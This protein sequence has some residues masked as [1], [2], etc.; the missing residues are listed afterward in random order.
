MYFPMTNLTNEV[1]MNMLSYL[2]VTSFV[3]HRICQLHDEIRATHNFR[4][5]SSL[6]Y[7]FGCALFGG[8]CKNHLQYY[9]AIML[10]L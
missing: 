7:T 10:H 5:V 2:S 8:R 4:F 1:T 3:R 9:N 6:G